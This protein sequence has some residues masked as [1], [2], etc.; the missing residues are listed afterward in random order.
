LPNAGSGRDG[1]YFDT[2]EYMFGPLRNTHSLFVDYNAAGI[3][4]R[5]RCS[6]H[7]ETFTEQLSSKLSMST[8]EAFIE[9]QYY[10][11]ENYNLSYNLFK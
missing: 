4:N 5:P 11:V 6:F 7:L 1:R 8:E 3:G 10:I 9:G 2:H